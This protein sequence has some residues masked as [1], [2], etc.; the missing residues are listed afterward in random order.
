MNKDLDKQ[1]TD[2]EK[3][4]IS[5]IVNIYNIDQTLQAVQGIKEAISNALKPIIENYSSIQT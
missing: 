5:E 1:K 4:D 2:P 3:I